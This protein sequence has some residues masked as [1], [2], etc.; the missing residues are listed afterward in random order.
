MIY[1]EET[2]TKRIKADSVSL[3][4]LFHWKIIFSFLENVNSVK[5]VNRK[6][7]DF[8]VRSYITRITVIME[9][10]SASKFTPRLSKM[11]KKRIAGIQVLDLSEWKCLNASS[12]NRIIRLKAFRHLKQLILGDCVNVN[13]EVLDIPKGIYV[14]ATTKNLRVMLL[15]VKRGMSSF[16]ERFTVFMHSFDPSNGGVDFFL[17]VCTVLN[18][19]V[20]ETLEE[21]EIPLSL[22]AVYDF[23]Y[24]NANMVY[25]YPDQMTACFQVT[26]VF[27]I[28]ISVLIVVTEVDSVF[29]LDFMNA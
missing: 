1:A 7:L 6:F 10:T 28:R 9:C 29:W 19:Q 27:A 22:A 4:T 18:V 2:I 11:F 5:A 13:A 26:G 8:L 23:C 16:F 17:E 12:L 24:G 15:N 14:S 21:G 25:C 3:L 20:K